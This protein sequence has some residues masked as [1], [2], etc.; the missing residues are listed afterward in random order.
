MFLFLPKQSS[1]L[2]VF[3]LHTTKRGFIFQSLYHST[4]VAEPE[5]TVLSVLTPALPLHHICG[6]ACEDLPLVARIDVK[7]RCALTEGL[8]YLPAVFSGLCRGAAPQQD[9]PSS[10]PHAPEPGLALHSSGDG[11]PASRWRLNKF[12]TLWRNSLVGSPQTAF[13]LLAQHGFEEF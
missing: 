11:A 1:K 10:W 4:V 5:K 2:F 6:L 3:Y 12:F 7:R 9:D 8:P 13:F